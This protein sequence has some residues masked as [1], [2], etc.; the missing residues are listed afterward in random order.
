MVLALVG[1]PSG[2]DLAT[3]AVQTDDPGELA[4]LLAP[5]QPV[6]PVPAPIII[7]AAYDPIPNG[8]KIEMGFHDTKSGE[9]RYYEA[10]VRGS[11]VLSQLVG[12]RRSSARARSDSFFYRFICFMFVLY[13]FHIC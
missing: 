8:T 12:V 1:I 4:P 3:T 5:V 9:L 11:T 6:Q 10:T 13:S 7:R 2:G